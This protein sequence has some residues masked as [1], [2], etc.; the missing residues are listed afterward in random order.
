MNIQGVCPNF[1]AATEERQTCLQT[2]TVAVFFMDDEWNIK[3]T[4]RELH[5]GQVKV[6]KAQKR[7]KDKSCCWSIS[8]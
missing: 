5:I 3:G 6:F 1:S 4:Q 7:K 2:G 8:Q